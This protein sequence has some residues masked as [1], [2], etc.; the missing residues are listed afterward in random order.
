MNIE[1]LQR[2]KQHILDEPRRLN[3]GTWVST[4]RKTVP[5]FTGVYGRGEADLPPCGTV[6]CVAGWAVLLSRFNGKP[7]EY[8]AFIRERNTLSPDGLTSSIGQEEL[9]LSPSQMETL[10]YVGRWPERF[11]VAH[12]QAEE[13]ADY[14]AM[15]QI[16]ADRIDYLIEAPDA[17]DN[18]YTV[19]KSYLDDDDDDI[20]ADNLE[21]D[22]PEDD[23]DGFELEDEDK[24]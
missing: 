6:A 21:F 20:P 14:Q 4:V 2:V 16:T 17:P 13:A 19:P 7:E 22:Q 24:E 5:A 1:L 11:R 3:M 18:N 8:A 23:E 12:E 9:G 15:A 10:F